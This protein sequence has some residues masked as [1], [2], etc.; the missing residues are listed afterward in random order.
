MTVSTTRDNQLALR[1]SQLSDFED[2]LTEF[3]DQLIYLTYVWRLPADH[4]QLPTLD[5]NVEVRGGIRGR[6]DAGCPREK[7][8][9]KKNLSGG[10]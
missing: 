6:R 5:V 9:C 10:L 1:G 3:D 7:V 2:Q 4:G 8:R